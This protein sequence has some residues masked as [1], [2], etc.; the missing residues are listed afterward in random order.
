MSF[1]AAQLSETMLR[2]T[3]KEARM[4]T[5]YTHPRMRELFMYFEA[6]IQL[7]VKGKLMD[8]VEHRLLSLSN[9]ERRLLA[10]Y[11]A[12]RSG[13]D[14]FDANNVIYAQVFE[15]WKSQ[16]VWNRFSSCRQVTELNSAGNI[17][18]AI[19]G[20]AWLLTNWLK[21]NLWRLSS[22]DHAPGLSAVDFK[23]QVLIVDEFTCFAKEVPTVFDFLLGLSADPDFMNV[24]AFFRL[25][26]LSIRLSI[27]ISGSVSDAAWRSYVCLSLISS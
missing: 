2:Q 1:P 4:N 12:V 17:M 25:F 5:E 20:T 7:M 26:F 13:G 18:E 8:F 15:Y 16:E 27:F 19:L 3:L 10:S 22:S 24:R 21:P 23:Y 6:S 14:W 9:R 11:G